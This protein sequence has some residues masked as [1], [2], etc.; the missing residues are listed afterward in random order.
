M[1]IQF[2]TMKIISILNKINFRRLEE[3]EEREA[4]QHKTGEEDYIKFPESLKGQEESGR[5][6]D[7]MVLRD[8]CRVR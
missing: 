5:I 3:V 4:K 2:V 8:E 1:I 7:V 6:R